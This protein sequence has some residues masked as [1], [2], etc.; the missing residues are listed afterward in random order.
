M[1]D[2]PTAMPVCDARHWYIATQKIM[3]QLT[4]KSS[5]SV[6]ETNETRSSH[7]KYGPKIENGAAHDQEPTTSNSFSQEITKDDTKKATSLERADNIG[8]QFGQF[9]STC[10]SK[11]EAAAKGR[12]RHG[13]SNEGRVVTKHG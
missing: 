10:A 2:A 7:L 5:S 8:L 1:E 9:I 4:C 11:M 3:E 6:E 13:S 12:E